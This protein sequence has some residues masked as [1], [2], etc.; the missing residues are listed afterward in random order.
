MSVPQHFSTFEDYFEQC[1]AFFEEYQNLYNFANT[2]VL[3]KGVLENIHFD[4]LKDI[5]VYN[6]DFDIRREAE[7]NGYLNAFFNK[8]DKLQVNYDFVDECNDEFTIDVPLTLKKKHEI[9][10]LAREIGK[11]CSRIGCDTVVDFGSGLV[12]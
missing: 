8:L 1:T 6:D 2:D 12:S 10:H 11:L 7:D 3:V 9:V 4:E 5:D